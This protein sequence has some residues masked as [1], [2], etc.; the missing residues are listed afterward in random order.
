MD[1]M[2]VALDTNVWLDWLVFDDPGIAPLK[3][4]KHSDTVEIVTDPRC[5]AELVRVLGYPQFRIDEPTQ[6]RLIAEADQLST[7]LDALRYPSAD[8]LPACSDPEDVKFLAL[9]SASRADWLITKDNA[10][11]A[12]S[13]KRKPFPTS[14]QIGTPAQWSSRNAAS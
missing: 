1:T 13:R 12:N 8:L 9:A 3:V 11:L 14:Y 2:R 10:L 5:R 7:L 4:A 6:A